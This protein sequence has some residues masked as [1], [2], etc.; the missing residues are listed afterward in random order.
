MRSESDAIEDPAGQPVQSPRR[1]PVFPPAGISGRIHTSQHSYS[2]AARSHFCS[3]AD[4]LF[5]SFRTFAF[6]SERS[7]SHLM[8]AFPSSD[9]PFRDILVD[10]QS[11]LISVPANTSVLLCSIRLSGALLPSLTTSY[12][13]FCRY[14]KKTP[15]IA[16]CLLAEK[17]YS[18]EKGFLYVP[19]REIGTEGLEPSPLSTHETALAT[20]SFETALTD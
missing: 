7:F 13:S 2:Q 4:R 3:P 18:F 8:R 15:S 16:R 11:Q 5:F 14:T 12:S 1:F 10:L 6:I 19:I 17:Y 20:I 9:C